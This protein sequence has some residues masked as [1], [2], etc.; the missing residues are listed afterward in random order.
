VLNND[1]V[2]QLEN[3]RLLMPVSL[4][5]TSNSEWSHKGELRCYYSDDQGK[6]WHSGDMVP[7]PDSIITQEPGVVELKSGKIMMIIRASGGRQYHSIS[8]DQGL[9]WSYAKPTDIASPISPASLERLP[10]TGDLLLVWNNNG[11]AGPG[12]YKAK[13]SPLTLAISQD[14]G[15]T[16]QHQQ[17]IETDSGGMYCY[18]AI[19]AI[20]DFVLLA[21]LSKLESDE[22]FGITMRRIGLREI[23]QGQ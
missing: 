20:G 8:E 7:S 18:T 4:H 12:Y 3:G 1:R 15:K 17:N 5:K 22:G 23:Y 10:S 19:Q 13:R 6:S 21:Y 14:D 16:W 11:K 9:S 2:L